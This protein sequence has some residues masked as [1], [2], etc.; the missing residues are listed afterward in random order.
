MPFLYLPSSTLSI[1]SCLVAIRARPRVCIENSDVHCAP[2]TPTYLNARN[3]TSK[4]RNLFAP[5][6]FSPILRHSHRFHHLSSLRLLAPPSPSAQD[7]ALSHSPR[8]ERPLHRRPHL[9]HP[10]QFFLRL[11]HAPSRGVRCFSF[12]PLLAFPSLYRCRHRTTST[13]TARRHNA[14]F[15]PP[16]FLNARRPFL[17]L[18]SLILAITYN[19]L[20]TMPTA[21]SYAQTTYSSSRR[22]WRDSIASFESGALGWEWKEEGGGSRYRDEEGAGGADETEEERL[23]GGRRHQEEN[24]RHSAFSFSSFISFSLLSLLRIAFLHSRPSL[25]LYISSSSNSPLRLQLVLLPRCLVFP[26]LLSLLNPHL[27][28]HLHYLL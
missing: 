9:F 23:A 1:L 18:S 5:F 3:E 21:L 22:E 11:S 19:S 13:A 6:F 27:P 7:S 8:R 17:A 25:R 24:G 12:R 16:F 4:R 15:L 10:P 14:S 20:R 28:P 26:F 2:S